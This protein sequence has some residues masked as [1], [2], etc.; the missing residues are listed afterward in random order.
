MSRKILALSALLLLA[1]AASAADTP[2][3]PVESRGEAVVAPTADQK[4]AQRVALELRKA[5][6]QEIRASIEADREAVAALTAQLADA[7]PE[8]RHA[9]QLQIHATKEQGRRALLAIQLDYAR[10]GGHDEQARELEAMLTRMDQ[11]PAKVL[12][13]P[14]TRD[15]RQGGESR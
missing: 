7:T 1:G 14:S 12:A 15:A 10:Q 3:V 2:P 8:Q 13:A 5:M 9:L 6:N 11:E 4:E